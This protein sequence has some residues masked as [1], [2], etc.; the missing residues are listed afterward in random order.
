MAS[1]PRHAFARGDNYGI[2]GYSVS[3]TGGQVNVSSGGIYSTYGDITLG[4]N[5][6]TDYITASGFTVKEGFYMKIADGQTLYGGGFPSASFTG[7]VDD[8]SALNGLKLR[9]TAAVTESGTNEYTILNAAGWDAFCDRL[10]ADGGKDFFSGKTVKLGADITVSRMAG[11]DYHDFC[12]TFDGQEHTLTVDISSDSRLYTAPFAYV[13]E[14]TPTGGPELSHP[15][16]RNLK[17]AGTVNATKDYAGGIV[18]AF[19]GTLTIENCTSSVTINTDNKHAAGFISDVHG[20]ATIRNSLSNV[21]INSTVSGDGTHAG[22]V[23]ANSGTL[24]ITGCAFTGS[25]LTTNGTTH[26]AGFVG[27]NGGTLN[28]TNSLYAPASKITL[29]EGVAATGTD[30]FTQSDGTFALPGAT[31]TLSAAGYT[32]SDV[33]AGNVTISLSEGVYSFTM[34]AANV[35]VTATLTVNPWSGSGDEADPYTIYNKDQLDLL[36]QRVNSGS[37]DAYAASGYEGRYFVL[38]GDIAYSH[39]TDWDNAESTEKNYTAIGGTFN[40]NYYYFKGHFDGQGHTI[41]GIR[42]YKGDDDYQGL[43]GQ[44]DDAD[45]RGI[46]LDDA[47]ITGYYSTGGIVGYNN[48]GTV[49]DCTSAATLTIDG[50]NCQ[51][52]GGIAGFNS[53]TLRHNLAIGA[54]VPAASNKSHGAIC[55]ANHGPLQNNYYHACRVASDVVTTSGVGYGGIRVSGGDYQTADVADGAEPGIV[56]YDH[57]SWTDLN[58]FVLATVVNHTEVD[59]EYNDL[60]KVPRVALAGRTLYKDGAWNTLCLPFDM[61]LDGSVLDDDDFGVDARFLASS[62]FSDG[63]L[64]LTFSEADDVTSIGPGE[65]HIIRWGTPE[66]NPGTTLAD[67]VFTDVLIPIDYT[68]AEAISEALDDA[69]NKTDY[70]D[71]RGSF[72]P[73][74]LAANDRSVLYLGAGNKLY[75]PSDDRTIGACRAWFQLK[76][77]LTAGEPVSGDGSGANVRAFKLNF[78]EET[79]GVGDATRLMDNGELIIDNE[80]GAW[81]DLSGRRVSVSSA[82]SA[83]SVLPKGVYIRNGK[84]V[85]IK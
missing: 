69:S 44:T 28:I 6:A 30:V 12:G 81:Y 13:S 48:H 50:S 76:N 45:I 55:G 19:W 85:V 35:T 65:T 24:N 41:S 63:T 75:W 84:K 31:V 77:G 25:L 67:P 51:D 58:S 16:L 64:T 14:T 72:S 62:E 32:L 59:E 33:S 78:G 9:P 1:L 79:T 54:I 70:V 57:S 8:P 82:S 17:V 21:T 29:P 52:Y 37:G 22:L 15:A 36:A 26:C 40:G 2:R 39:T 49:S 20:N 3:I 47:R 61:D 60:V 71:F 5:S 23:A 83:S 56:L 66:S 27:Y 68:S 4:W 34:P 10:A 74:T 53:G 43:F 46:T 73:V 80:A 42:I 38:G 7:T 11:A 18:G